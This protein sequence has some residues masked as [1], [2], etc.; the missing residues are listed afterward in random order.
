MLPARRLRPTAFPPAG[1]RGCPRPLRPCL[2][3]FGPFPPVSP[4]LPQDSISVSGGCR[5]PWQLRHIGG[6]IKDAEGPTARGKE[7]KPARG[8]RHQVP[9]LQTRPRVP[10]ALGPYTLTQGSGFWGRNSGEVA[11]Q[12]AP[13]SS[14]L[15]D[16]GWPVIPTILSCC[17][18]HTFCPA[19]RNVSPRR[20]GAGKTGLPPCLS[21]R[22]AAPGGHG[23]AHT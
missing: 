18:R 20:V 11:R 10:L 9:R 12:P 6:P 21:V 23:A 16:E 1:A 7:R 15:S 22:P 3:P 17:V 2:S 4:L 5:S 14:T 19:R 13:P 8:P